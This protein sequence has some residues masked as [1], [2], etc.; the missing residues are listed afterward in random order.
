[1]GR[2][3]LIASCIAAVAPPTPA[4]SGAFSLTK[5]MTL[6]HLMRDQTTNPKSTYPEFFPQNLLILPPQTRFLCEN[7][8]RTAYK[9]VHF[10]EK[11][12]NVNINTLFCEK[13]FKFCRFRICCLMSLHLNKFFY[14]A[15]TIE[16][17]THVLNQLSSITLFFVTIGNLNFTT[18]KRKYSLFK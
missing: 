9:M 18:E 2:E 3:G 5:S 10:Y 4:I 12:H 16:C 14:W 11:K 8:N 17:I 15:W 13:K 6:N 7:Q 1:M